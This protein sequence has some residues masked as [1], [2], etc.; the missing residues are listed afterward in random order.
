MS[1]DN[2]SQ[3]SLPPTA[4]PRVKFD[5]P[6]PAAASGGCGPRK[7]ITLNIDTSLASEKGGKGGDTHN[8]PPFP[9]TPPPWLAK[10]RPSL[11]PSRR[12]SRMTATATATA[13]AEEDGPH[14]TRSRS[15]R[16][17]SSV[18]AAFRRPSASLVLH[19]GREKQQGVVVEPRRPPVYNLFGHHR[20]QH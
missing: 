14:D 18:S 15:S 17:R 1:G 2:L 3:S 12:Q 6:C 16:I 9:R 5:R 19:G 8:H 13:Q 4:G 11:L 10:R 7:P 20:R